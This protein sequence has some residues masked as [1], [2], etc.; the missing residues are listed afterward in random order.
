MVQGA[1][2]D[3][4]DAVAR[5]AR[6]LDEAG[7]PG[8]VRRLTAS[9]RTA[10][11]AAQALGCAVGAIANS[12]VFDADGEPVLVIASGAHRVDTDLVAE[13]LDAGSVRRAPP[14]QVR[15]A[16]GFVIGGVAPVA[17]PAPM[18][19]LLDATLAAYDTV[20]ASAG[21]PHA[22]FSAAFDELQRLTGAPVVVVARD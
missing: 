18:R 7:M 3:V 10:A 8:R 1:S 12:L 19:T 4:G 22:V 6:R 13:L 9:A 14:D 5:V 17:H 16:T 20:W 21:H 2:A 15:R 11:D